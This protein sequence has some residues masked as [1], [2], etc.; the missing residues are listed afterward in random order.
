MTRFLQ[1]FRA[2]QLAQAAAVTAERRLRKLARNEL[3][4]GAAPSN[5]LVGEADALHARAAAL[6]AATFAADGV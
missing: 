6:L 5:F 1:L 4:G 3:R 2:W